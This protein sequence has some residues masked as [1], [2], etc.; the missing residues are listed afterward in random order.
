MIMKAII[1]YHAS[2]Q[3]PSCTRKIGLTLVG[4]LL[5][6]CLLQFS[7]IALL[8]SAALADYIRFCHTPFILYLSPMFVNVAL[9]ALLLNAFPVMI[10]PWKASSVCAAAS[11]G[12]AV[13]IFVQ[14]FAIVVGIGA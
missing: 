7:L 4:L 2:D 14:T 3:S 6:G 1:D 11:V 13:A 8:N 12:V 9:F 5:L 10:R